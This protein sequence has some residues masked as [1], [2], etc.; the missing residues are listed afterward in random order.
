M[1]ARYAVARSRS[2]V[3][4]RIPRGGDRVATRRERVVLDLQDNFTGGMA[5]AAA[6]TAMLNRELNSLSG[7]SLA[8]ARSSQTFSRDI[9][10]MG[11]DANGAGTSINQLTGRIRVLAEVAAILGP[12][13]APL[14]GVA[15]AGV[16]GLANQMGAAA[17]A[18][19][20]LI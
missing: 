10:R 20:V 11:N 5:R 4:V 18:G 3:N 2:S 8:T 13:L 9:E 12:S 15:I 19:G 17:I 1:A 6:A 16:A 7:Q 14:G